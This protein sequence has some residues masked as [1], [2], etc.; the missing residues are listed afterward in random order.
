MCVC[1]CGG[2]GGGGGGGEGHNQ[3]LCFYISVIKPVSG[4]VTYSH[5]DNG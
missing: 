5:F 4:M 2:G 1:V 3:L